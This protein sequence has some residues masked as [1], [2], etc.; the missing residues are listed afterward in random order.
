MLCACDSSKS[1][2]SSS[3]DEKQDKPLDP[4]KHPELNI[5]SIPEAKAKI[6][7][8]KWKQYFYPAMITKI[9]GKKYLLMGF[10]VGFYYTVQ[11]LACVSACNFY[12]DASRYAPC[13]LTDDTTLEGEDASAV[14]DWAIFLGGVFHVVEWIRTTILLTVI[15][16]GANL[17]I[18]WYL[19]GLLSFVFG[20][21]T[22]AYL[23]YVYFGTEAASACSESQPQ[24]H[25]WLLAEIIY[26]W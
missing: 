17:M 8:L 26:F 9:M 13:I 1:S 15:C 2:V 18:V 25:Q 11:F 20:L 6:V 12:S 5:D 4:S 19:S 22:F 16:I 7:K 23:Q 3:D 10:L 14:Y 24:R 21:G